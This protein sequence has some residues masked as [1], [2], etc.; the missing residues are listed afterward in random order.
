[1]SNSTATFDPSSSSFFVALQDGYDRI[2]SVVEN[3][4]F[5][6]V[7]NGESEKTPVIDAVLI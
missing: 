3:D 2:L 6:F 7:V 5:L 1:M 4:A